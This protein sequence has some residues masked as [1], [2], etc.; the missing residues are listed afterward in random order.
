MKFFQLL[1]TVA[2]LAV[3]LGMPTEQQEPK[4]GDAAVAGAELDPDVAH[5]LFGMLAFGLVAVTLAMPTNQEASS[6]AAGAAEINPDAAN[7]L[8]SSLLTLF[9]DTFTN[10][11]TAITTAISGVTTALG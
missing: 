3:T 8:F 10:V 7:G 4:S 6:D 1:L 9:T 11:S 2:L 5:G